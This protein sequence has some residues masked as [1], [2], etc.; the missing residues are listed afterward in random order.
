MH[1]HENRL[2]LVPHDTSEP[3]SAPIVMEISYEYDTGRSVGK[4]VSFPDMRVGRT[5]LNT[6]KA[7]GISATVISYGHTFENVPEVFITPLNSTRATSFGSVSYHISSRSRSQF[8][9][10]FNNG[11]P[12]DH[13]TWISW[14][15]IDSAQ[16]YDANV[17]DTE[18]IEVPEYLNLNP[19]DEEDGEDMSD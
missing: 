6:A 5:G 18:D 17:S 9:V 7:N 13:N 14:M 12:S 16:T 2:D 11:S 15:A 4:L 1:T 3:T 19:Q 8:T 10:V